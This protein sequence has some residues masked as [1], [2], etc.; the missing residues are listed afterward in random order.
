MIGFL[1]FF[2]GLLVS[3]GMCGIAAF[4]DYRG[5]RIPNMVSIVIVAAFAVAFGVLTLTDQRSGVFL[6]LSS[7][8]I[9]A[10]VVL[11]VTAVMFALK[12]LGAGDSK[13][14]TAVALWAGLPGLAPFLFYMALSGGVIA[15]ASLALKRWK[16]FSSPAEGGWIAKAQEG[17]NQVPYGIA[18]AIGALAAFLSRGYFSPSVWQGMFE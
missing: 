2:F 12:Q 6:A 8:L 7:H 11:A 9:G 1:F 17:A 15:G 10:G 18:I 4:S 5:F 16:P 13:F 3:L 14:A